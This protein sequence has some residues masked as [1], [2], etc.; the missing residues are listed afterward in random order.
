MRKGFTL[1]L[2]LVPV[3]ADSKFPGSNGTDQE[4]IECFKESSRPSIECSSEIHATKCLSIS[5]FSNRDF[6]ASGIYCQLDDDEMYQLRVSE[7]LKYELVSSG[8]DRYDLFRLIKSKRGKWVGVVIYTGFKSSEWLEDVNW[9]GYSLDA[10][11]GESIYDYTE[12]KLNATF[13]EAPMPY[14]QALRIANDYRAK[15][16]NA[17]ELLFCDRTLEQPEHMKQGFC[18]SYWIAAA[19]LTEIG[20]NNVEA[21]NRYKNARNC[22]G[23]QIRKLERQ[24]VPI[25]SHLRW[26]MAEISHLLAMSLVKAGRLQEARAEVLVGLAHSPEQ[27]QR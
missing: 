17:C 5:G 3:I 16:I 25:T 12:P 7:T 23:G 1:A 20:G 19:Q 8:L 4:L 18:D 11:E 6:A 21:A 27:K 9:T 10:R 2:C 24:R 26:K 14:V 22:I 15:N 13:V